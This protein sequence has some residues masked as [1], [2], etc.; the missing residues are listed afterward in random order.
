MVELHCRTAG[1]HGIEMRAAD[2]LHRAHHFDAELATLMKIS[3]KGLRDHAKGIHL[4]FPPRIL[5]QALADK[6]AATRAQ[7]FLDDILKYVKD[8]ANAIQAQ[9]G[10]CQPLVDGEAEV[11]H[12]CIC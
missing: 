9:D 1:L 7:E 2:N 3:M 4:E 6:I 10:A 11:T 8:V 5:K 12:T